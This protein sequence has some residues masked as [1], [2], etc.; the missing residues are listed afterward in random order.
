VPGVDLRRDGDER[1][2]EVL[3]VQAFQML[4]HAL[5]QP[6]AAEQAAAADRQIEQAGDTAHGQ[7]AGKILQFVQLAGEIAAADQRADRGAGDHADLDARFVERAQH[8]DMRPAARC[9]AA[10]CK[11]K[12]WFFRSGR[13]GSGF[14]SEDEGVPESEL[15]GSEL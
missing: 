14:I 2:V 5:R 4:L 3:D 9:A 1:A 11:G 13:R 6:H 8:T 10:E 7:A 15:P 12:L